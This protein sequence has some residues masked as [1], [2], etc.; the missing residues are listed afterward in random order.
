[1]GELFFLQDSGRASGKGRCMILFLPFYII[2][3]FNEIARFSYIRIKKKIT[4]LWFSFLHDDYNH[5]DGQKNNNQQHKKKEKSFMNERTK[6]S[7]LKQS[8]GWVLKF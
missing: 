1:M 3:A 8:V 7:S 2:L 5:F 6:Q 4:N